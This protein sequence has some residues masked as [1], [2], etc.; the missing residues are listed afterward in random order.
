MKNITFLSK[1]LIV[2]MFFAISQLFSQNL[3]PFMPRYDQAIKGDILLIGNSNVGIHVS[4]PYNGTDTNDRI[5]AAV[6]VDI[7]GDPSTFNSSSADLDVPNNVNCYKIVYAGLYWSAVVNGADPISDI[8]FKVPGG[9]Y[10]D[11]TGTQIYFQNAADNTDSNTYVYYQDVTNLVAALANPEGTYAV[12]NISSLVG[13]KPN[14]E[15]LSAGWSLFIIYE[16][17]LLPSKYITSFDGFTKITST[18]NE[19]FP[20]S[21]FTTI[22]VGPVRAKFA[23]STIEGD[24]RYTGDYL[25]L[26][27]STISATNNAGTVIRPGNNFFNS[28]VSYI[29]PVT[30]TPELFTTRVPDGSNTLGFDAG[31]I[32]IP[33][34][35]NTLIPN[36]A[37]SATIS[38]GS[39]LD[40]YYYYFSAFAIE[41]IAPDIV[42]TKIVEDEFGNDIGG[43]IVNLGDELYYT[44]AFQN[45]GN[46]DA[47]NLTIRDI[48][49]TNIIFNYPAD[50]GFLPPGVTVQSYDPIT[51]ELI[52]RIDESIVEEND[53]VS[54]IRFKVTVVYT[55]S[56][57]SDACSSNIDNQAYATY[58]GTINPN[59]TISDDPSFNTNTGCLLTPG[60]AN[61]LADI[62]NCA[63]E[64]EVI[65]CGTNVTLTAGS[66]YDTYSW[67]TSSTGTP[68]IGTTQ[69]IT[70]TTPGTYYVHNTAIAPCQ[71]IDQVFNVVTF[72]VGVTNPLIPFAD[73]VV[74][75]PNDGKLL[76]NFFLCGA[77]D[78][79]FIQTNIT[80]ATSIIWEKLDETSCSAVPDIDCANENPSCTWNQI[81]SGPDFMIDTAGQYRLSLNY[82]GGCFNQFY[83]N[84]YEN[85]LV[86]TVTS[87]DIIC[88]TLGEITVGG[89]P[90]GYEYSIDGVNYQPSNIF[91]IATPNLYQ[92]YI[93]QIGVTPNPCIFTVPDVLIRQRDFTVSTIITQPF[94]YGEKGTVILAANDV[95]AQYFYSI[96]QGATLINSVGPVMESDYTFAN[97]NPGTYTVNVST[98]DGCIYTGSIDIINPPL[99]TATSALTKPLTCTDGEITVYPVGGTP[100]YYYFVNSTTVFQSTPIITVS[101]SGTYNITVVDSNNC[102]ADTSITVNAIPAPD[103]NVTQTNILCANSGNNGIININVTN[104]NG[105]SLMYSIDNGVTFFNSPIF[106][107]LAIGN[108]NVVVQYSI[109]T[110]VCTT[111][112]QPITI[113]EVPPIN[114]TATISTPYTCTT[115]G[116]ITVSGVSGGT[117]PYTY[118]LDG[119]NF[120]PGTN[121]SGLKN[122]TYV[123]TIKDASGCFF[124]IAPITIDPLNP[125]TDLA[126]SKTPLTCPLNVSTVTL[127][128]TGGTGILEYQIIL[129]VAAA[130]IYQTSNVFAGLT[131]NTY[132]FRVK[133]ANDCTYIESFTIAPLPVTTV[134]TVLTKDLDCSISPDGI[135]NGN[136][137]GGTAPFAYQVSFNGGGFGAS[138]AVTGTSFSHTAATNGTYQFLITDANGCTAQSGVQTI[139]IP[140]LV[141]ASSTFI[142]PTCNGFSDGSIRLRALTGQGPF[143]YSIDSGTTFVSSNVFGGLVAGSYNYVVRDSKS[144]EAMGTI[145][146]VDPLPIDVS[147]IRNPVQCISNI[148]GS[149]DITINSGG[150]APFVYTLY[151]NAN[152]QIGASVTTAST[153]N[154]FSGLYFGDYYITIVDSKGCEFRSQRQR[155]ETPPNI[156]LDGNVSTGSCA[157]GATVDISILAGTGPF[158]YSI[159][160]QPATAVGP[161]ASTT[162]TFTGL[163][164]GV[165]YQFEVEDAGGC[166]SIIEVT[167]PV[168]SPID[169]DPINTANVTCN[170]GN[171]GSASFTVI[172]YD[173]SVTSLYYEVLDEL[174]NAPIIPAQNGTFTGLTG[175]SVS[176]TITGLSAG[177]YTL[178]IRETDGTLCTVSKPFQITQ[179]IQPL[180]SVI[181][182]EENANC[183]VYSQVTLTTIGGT[184]P[185]L[186]AAG[187]PGFIPT[188]GD[189]GPINVLN[190]DYNIR[191]NWD[192]VVRDII[193][194]EVRLNESIDLDPA[195]IIAAT[196]NN[197]CAVTEGNFAI[198]VALT[199]AGIPPYAYSIDGGSFQ[200]RLA[201]FTIS[202]LASGTHTIEVHDANGC[203]NLETI[204]ISPPLELIPA[205]TVLPT[206]NDDDGEIT[207]TASGGSGNYSY[208]ILSPIIVPAQAS[209]IFTGLGTGT[210]TLR[211]TD[212]TDACFKDITAVLPAAIPLTFTTSSTAVICFGD[213]GSFEMNLNGYSGPYNYE[214]F[215]SLGASFTTGTGDS[216]LLNPETVSLIPAGNY[217]VTVTELN[218]PYCSA[219]SSV[220]IASPIDVLTLLASETSSVTCDDGQGT[221]TALAS[222]GWGSYE[223]ELTGAATVPYS[224]TGIFRNLSAGNYTVNVR[225]VEGCI[226]TTNLTLVIP[227]PINAT[228]T[229]TNSVLS[230]F[231]DTSATITVNTVNGG[232]GSNYTY[233]LNMVSPTTSSSGPQLSPV[234][235]GLGAGVYNIT[236]TDGYNCS[237]NSPNLVITEPSEVQALLV[238]GTTQTCLTNATLTLSANGGIGPYEYSDT[239]SFTTILG[240]FVSSTTINVAPGTYVYYVRDSNGCINNVSNQISIDPLPTLLVNLDVTNATINCNGDSTGVIIA[241]AEGGLGNYIYTLQDVSGTNI[242][243]AIQNTPGVFTDLPVG[244]YQ[245]RVD[246][247]DCLST[248]A[249]VTITQP[250]LPLTVS[251][252][253]N[254]V[255]CNGSNNGVIDINA[256]GGTGIIKYAI[257]PQL[258]QF[259]ESS[260]FENLSPG[261]YQAIA[262]DELGCF[263]I[264]DFTI[265]EPAPVVLS[266]VP[267]SIIP[268]VCFGDMN[269][270][271]SIDISG[272]TE[273]Y[274]VS[275]DDIDG[276]YTIGV[277]GQTQ[278]DFTGLEGGDHVV[279][280]R[281]NEG[282]E[283]EW[284][285]SFPESVLINAEVVI[286]YCTNNTDASS[287]SVIVYVD[288]STVNP[289]DID[290][291]LDGGAYQVSNVFNDLVSGSHVITLRHTNTCEKSINFEIEQFDPLQIAI[292][293]GNLNEIVATATGGS[294]IY[295]YY[296]T[297]ETTSTTELYGNTNTF[298]IYESANYT[299]KVTDS[300]G[301]IASAT[302]YFEHIDVCVTNYFTPNDDGN[303]DEWGP[304]CTNQYRNLTY[305]IFDRYG[306]KLVTLGVGEKWDGK[307]NGIE[308][309][310]G[311]Y[312]YV[313]RLNDIKDD[314]HFVGNFTLYM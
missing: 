187:A 221:I 234:F 247:G 257:S 67:S 191:T 39:N 203:G 266:I 47:T 141:T 305:D 170:G 281:D 9:S 295:T 214:V 230:C 271:F 172:N 75:C 246:S 123:V 103:F 70:V 72:G 46:D 87:R 205:V 218:S 114:G 245:V 259:F 18:I 130:T 55:C 43:Q 146:L 6:Y 258:N 243:G 125:P 162:N 124:A 140:V 198:D 206:C 19:T 60:P 22:P 209:N 283:S 176:G 156:Q 59:F 222:G 165:T 174:T 252:T 108:Y 102:S 184:G 74:T 216:S 24:R 197:Q 242:P 264:F 263:V 90:S 29:D 63:F 16:D 86:P 42:L 93:R 73:Q 236:V 52:F 104:A 105:N 160:G 21:G 77:N 4:N 268:E 81:A 260:T 274:S 131:P 297:N 225:D 255:T 28:T 32:N 17:P 296:V 107:G 135:I 275:L 282:C 228:V 310:T 223:Y 284:N 119:L 112:A 261:T 79:R 64:E 286:E 220:I 185:Y 270:E 150:V 117:A 303:L 248:S 26:N 50:I 312:W 158:I 143:T 8:K 1:G 65:L 138:T 194:C 96:Y 31:I 92:V 56:L 12:A 249:T 273:P 215:D 163:N 120:Q 153:T 142:N 78:S 27:G 238:K 201:P 229:A 89:V 256:S 91:S 97:L 269:G 277:V 171:D 251:Y 207:L 161:T 51:R 66:G 178:F 118:S 137:S 61:F 48:L 279:Y 85:L 157:T 173:A 129:P 309:P 76:P 133:D 13:P 23:F 49:P 181:I 231:G 294:G 99:L 80:D 267:N 189:F 276:V 288:D 193:G 83:F 110:D 36:G 208:E 101:T 307:Y 148:L 298:V 300:N 289:T 314:R 239:A 196:I 127:T 121:F 30:N 34:A 272:G 179:P 144:C 262:Q 240:S 217:T 10:T 147:I 166:F 213:T 69:S 155:I 306:R 154:T 202:N 285:I 106:T 226:A 62:S 95:G 94:C 111:A 45:K 188:A 38:L 53:P 116:T 84:V 233:V 254:D 304:G 199:T 128:P 100:P 291:S 5:D 227:P 224:S 210:Y 177:N 290:Y 139:N 33:N 37:T 250:A 2:I 180:F 20:V 308:L 183:N 167:T 265:T 244:T 212:L 299:V 98:D 40:I 164:H 190:L 58:Q 15:G 278:F 311:D 182:S 11:I 14:S 253:I 41:I 136:I 204:I 159:Y 54:E 126:F 25:R 302:R 44:I 132:T 3:V 313:V 7:D 71:S 151:N 301:C 293:D 195:P 169:I 82:T 122:G 219:T 186:Y 292:D 287:N 134:N 88:T 211:V 175:A 241:L 280:V 145:N 235:D 237:F 232:Q 35:G 57:L 149:L 68:V 109:G 115:N 168:L 152:V 192:I 200:T 113:T